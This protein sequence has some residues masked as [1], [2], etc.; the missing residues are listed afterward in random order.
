MYDLPGLPEFIYK[1]VDKLRRDNICGNSF[2]TQPLF[3]ELYVRI[4]RR[5]LESKWF[6]CIDIARVEVI[7]PGKKHF[8]NLVGYIRTWHPELAIYIECVQ[9]LRFQVGL[10]KMGFTLSENNKAC[11]YLLPKE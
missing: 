9:E 10:I 11:F 4:T 1:G 2:V 7:T 3:K 6:P 5:Y 8:T